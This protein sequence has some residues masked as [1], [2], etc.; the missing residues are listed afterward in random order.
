LGFD[1]DGASQLDDVVGW[2]MREA[3]AAASKDYLVGSIPLVGA[4]FGEVI[5]RTCGGHWVRARETN[6]T[7]IEFPS[8]LLV[9]S[10][11]VVVARFTG[12][13]TGRF[14]EFYDE[15]VAAA[16]VELAVPAD[17]NVSRDMAALAAA[18][19]R[20]SAEEGRV[21]GYDV[22]SAYRL[23]AA[24][25]DFLP[26]RPSADYL[27][28]MIMSMGAYLGELLVR[29]RGG[30]WV[31]KAGSQEPAVELG[32]GFEAF[33]LNTVAKRITIGPEHSITQ[34]FDAGADPASLH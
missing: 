18:F 30:R 29:H 15:V 26:T 10:H 7:A 4:Y 20:G 14:L 19:V 2:L 17:D 31:A 9:M 1:R 25:D 12:G 24:V 32:D 16:K 3:E 22:E 5:R 34:F 8:G 6:Y 28:S 23:D 13:P 27:H 33:P 21:F 11:W